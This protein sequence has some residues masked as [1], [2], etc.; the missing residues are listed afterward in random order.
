MASGPLSYRKLQ[1]MGPRS[2]NRTRGTVVGG[3][4][5]GPAQLG[6]LPAPQSIYWYNISIRRLY[7]S[8]HQLIPLTSKLI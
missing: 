4:G 5:G 8:Q 2:E 3:G 1:E 7:I 6:A